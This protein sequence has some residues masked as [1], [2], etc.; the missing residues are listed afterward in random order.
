[1]TVRSRW[2][3]LLAGRLFSVLVATAALLCGVNAFVRAFPI[4]ASPALSV[5]SPEFREQ[6]R[7]VKSRLPAGASVLYVSA[8][9]E[10]W[11]SRLWQRALYPD[12]RTI[13]VQPWNFSKLAELRAKYN[14]RFA[15]SAGQPPHDLGFVWKVDLGVVPGLQGVSWFGELAP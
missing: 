15:I 6:V 1:V 4:A 3:L 5:F 13:V 8:Q 9:P 10:G 11:F 12:Y 14:A 2:R 7:L